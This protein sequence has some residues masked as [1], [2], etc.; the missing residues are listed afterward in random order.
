LSKL[1]SAA[2]NFFR[3]FF[4]NKQKEGRIDERIFT[5]NNEEVKG[6]VFQENQLGGP[7]NGLR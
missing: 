4:Q 7:Y 3:I 5:S 6:T 1:K 2:Q